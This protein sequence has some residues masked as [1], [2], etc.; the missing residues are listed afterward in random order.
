MKS[1][2][3]ILF[4]AITLSLGVVVTRYLFDLDLTDLV[5]APESDS[6]LTVSHSKK[7]AEYREY[8]ELEKS[9]LAE[10][11]ADSDRRMADDLKLD[12]ELQALDKKLG[13]PSD[14][15]EKEYPEFQ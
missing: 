15:F 1:K 6:E 7:L 11:N 2:L 10:L 13:I 9:S 14:Q 8:I 3:V 4:V 5:A 12:A